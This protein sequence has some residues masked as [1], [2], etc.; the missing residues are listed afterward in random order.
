MRIKYEEIERIDQRPAVHK[1]HIEDNHFEVGDSARMVLVKGE[2]NSFPIVE[3]R[4]HAT[5]LRPYESQIIDDLSEVIQQVKDDYAQVHLNGIPLQ[6]MN[7]YFNIGA[8]E[9][10]FPIRW[11]QTPLSVEVYDRK[12]KK[13][14][15]KGLEFEVLSERNIPQLR[16]LIRNWSK[17]KKKA[18]FSTFYLGEVNSARDI[19][20]SISKLQALQTEIEWMDFKEQNDNY[21]KKQ[22][23]KPITTFYGAF[24][25]GQ[26]LA[27]SEIQA[28]K[29]FAS[30]ETRGALRQNSFSPQ[31][32]LDYCI[33]RELSG[34]GVRVIDRGPLEIRKGASGL[35]E[36]KKKFGP[37]VI[38]REID[39]KNVSVFN[40]SLFD[41]AKEMQGIPFN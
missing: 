10:C 6:E 36:Y 35:I 21:Y 33:M 41:M 26:L 11:Y 20:Q 13:F 17:S 24:R 14:R 30:F 37:L 12:L 3:C 40:D 29:S 38:Q 23:S 15:N 4:G 34:N 28:N 9:S 8:S 2:Y 19:T 39:R 27:Y 7:K 32:F 31:E 18:A 16:E 22:M 25:D 1:S 5:I